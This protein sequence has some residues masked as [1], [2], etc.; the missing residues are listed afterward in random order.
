MASTSETQGKGEQPSFSLQGDFY[1]KWKEAGAEHGEWG[2]PVTGYIK[3]AGGEAVY[4]ERGLM[5]RGVA[6]GGA[7]VRCRLHPPLLGRPRI[8]NP[9][10]AQP[11]LPELFRWHLEQDT[12]ER[13]QQEEPGLFARLWEGLALQKVVEEGTP[14]QVV[15]VRV[16][17]I[18]HTEVGESDAEGVTLVQDGELHPDG[19]A[20]EDRSLY[21]LSLRLPG[22]ELYP[23]A[24]HALYA[25]R[26]WERFG[27][28]HAT[29]L[30]I[31]SRVETFKPRLRA[32]SFEEGAEACANYNDALRDMIRYANGLHD[33]GALDLI[34]MTGD[35]TD[36]LYEVGD[37]REGGGNFTFFERIIRGQAPSPEGVANPELRVPIFTVLGNHDYRP[38]PYDLLSD[39][40][41]GDTGDFDLFPDGLWSPERT[42]NIGAFGSFNLTQQEASALQGGKK[43][44]LNMKQ[45]N[46][47]VMVDPDKLAYYRQ[48]INDI[49]S[50]VVELGPHR[51]VML[52]S[53]WEEGIIKRSFESFLKVVSGHLNEDSR[54]WLEQH[55]NLVGFDEEELTLV[56][57][58]LKDADGIVV[59]GVHGPPL[60][61]SGDEYAHY[62]RETEHPTAD[63]EEVIGYLRRR[64][65]MAFRHRGV[66]PIPADVDEVYKNWPR[67][68]TPYFKCGGVGD[69]LDY[70]ISRG[71]ADEFLCLCAG[72]GVSRPVDLVLCG[73]IHR[74]VEYRV[75]LDPDGETLFYLDFYSENPQAY[76]S[77][78]CN[79]DIQS[80]DGMLRKGDQIHI[81]VEENAQPGAAPTPA[82]PG[83]GRLAVPPY[84]TP[85]NS[86]ADPRA[87]W[88]ERRPLVMQTAA[89]G[90]ID[91]NQRADMPNASFQGF[92]VL[93]VEGNTIR[94]ISYVTLA[95]L[96]RDAISLK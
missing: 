55:P 67:T 24:P 88:E 35:L 43:P 30:H 63:P 12:L 76:Y 61:P 11:L 13:I 66:L 46:D 34:V 28:I 51:I 56:R 22:G 86:A 23:L 48:R 3:I 47:V 8:A 92:R 17:A 10:D 89:M 44:C 95:E 32:L 42:K 36:Y 75:G 41:L 60:N 7:L 71:S 25:R 90:P 33:A 6:S 18:T 74:N 81:E 19:P 73:H 38:N 64:D 52:D 40:D 82:Q 96:R 83:H 16:G 14:A 65:A 15:A 85:L 87:W 80:D 39:L 27:F 21:N 68:G 4:F 77:T 49:M 93:S 2:A 78:V 37:D 9:D 91:T 20:L 62:F 84:A 5:W 45:A 31:S 69:L 26:S 29:D 79:V 50:Y 94:R 72:E 57:G 70:G 54:N 1:K 58:A 53:R 59:V